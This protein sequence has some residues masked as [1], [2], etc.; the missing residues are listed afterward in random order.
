MGATNFVTIIENDSTNVAMRVEAGDPIN[1]HIFRVADEYYPGRVVTREDP[2]NLLS[3]QLTILYTESFAGKADDYEFEWKKAKPNANGSMSTDYEK[4]YGDVVRFNVRSI[5]LLENLKGKMVRN[6]VISMNDEDL[7]NVD[8]LRQQL[9]V[10]GDNR[11]ELY[12]RMKDQISGNYVML[13]SKKLIAVDKHLLEA[14]REAGVS[15]KIN[16]RL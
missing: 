9:G 10:E 13:R 15:Y 12:F 6:L 1:M 5:D 3:Q 4:G 16:A 8:F 7:L 14:L 11:C 2:L